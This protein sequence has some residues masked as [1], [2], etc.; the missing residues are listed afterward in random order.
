MNNV[1]NVFNS[2]LPKVL[3]KFTY[4]SGKLLYKEIKAFLLLQN[5][6]AETKIKY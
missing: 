3:T 6:I 4:L 2:G 5:V 1:Q